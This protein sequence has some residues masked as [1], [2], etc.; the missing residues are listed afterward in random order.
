MGIIHPVYS[1]SRTATKG[2]R[3]MALASGTYYVTSAQILPVSTG[4]VF[5]S[6]VLTN[7]GINLNWVN[8]SRA[9]GSFDSVGTSIQFTGGARPTN[10][11][12]N[13]DTAGLGTL[14]SDTVYG[15]A[16]S[17]RIYCSGAKSTGWAVTGYLTSGRTQISRSKAFLV[18]QTGYFNYVLGA[19]G[20]GWGLN[21][22]S[23]TYVGSLELALKFG[24][25]PTLSGGIYLDSVGYYLSTGPIRS[26]QTVNTTPSYP[27][28]RR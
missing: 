12:F 6:G 14:P 18:N 26:S 28:Y 22:I 23:T 8:L 7:S 11:Y 5:E 20:D 16:A 3:Q 24:L 10:L 27:T 17:V 9:S 19:T 21:D 15:F 1:R 13:L 4:V 25:P 2:L